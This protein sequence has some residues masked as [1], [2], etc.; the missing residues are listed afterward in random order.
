MVP[1]V[2][3]LNTMVVMAEAEQ[4]VCAAG[5][6][7]ATGA[8][9]PAAIVKLTLPVAPRLSVTSTACKPGTLAPPSKV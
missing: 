5:V 9:A 4:V 3:L 8:G 6:A 2:E 1:P 7:V